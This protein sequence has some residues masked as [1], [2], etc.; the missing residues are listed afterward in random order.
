MIVENFIT[1][2]NK[3]MLFS[4]YINRASGFPKPLTNKEER[5]LLEKMHAGDIEAKQKLIEHNLRLVAHIV[6]KYSGSGEAEDMISV[7][8]IGLIKAINTYKLDKNTL[9]STYASRCIENEIL[10]LLRSNKKHL[11]NTS[12]FNTLG[13]DKD[14]NEIT[15]EDILPAPEDEQFKIERQNSYEKM[16]EIIN[17]HLTQREKQIIIMRYG[18]F[19]TKPLTQMQIAKKLGISRSYISRIESKALAT[20]SK[21]KDKIG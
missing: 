17:K 12:L 18:L 13:S 9:L 21:H 7:G 10:M 3:I 4:G 1:F 19:N 14:G 20:L 11:Q 2:L 15:I 16:Y 5:E 8:S 6:K